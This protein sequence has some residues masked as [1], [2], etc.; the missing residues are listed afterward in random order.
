MNVILQWLA[1]QTYLFYLAA[2]L[3]VIGYILATLSARRRLRA[4]QFTLE[5]ERIQQQIGRARI[6]IGLFLLLSGL[7]FTIDNYIVPELPTIAT[8]TPE[9][10]TGLTPP[11]TKTATPTPTATATLPPL[12]TATPTPL[13]GAAPTATP[14]PTQ[15]PPAEPPDCPSPDV[16][17]IAPATGSRLGGIVKIQGTAKINSFAYY[18][19]EVLFPDS[20]MPNFIEQFDRPVENGD[21][22]SWDISNPEL[23]PAG[24]PYKFRLVAVDI[25]GNTTNCTIPVYIENQ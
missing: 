10:A 6:M 7:V 13:G 9:L 22:G 24:G 18:K 8:P 2:L 21:L 4:A 5:R 1:R 15:L 19:F 25:Y 23:Y 14:T 3:G 20:E 11:A 12:E 16:Q 17:I